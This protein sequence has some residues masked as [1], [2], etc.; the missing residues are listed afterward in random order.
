MLTLTHLNSQKAVY[1]EGFG[2]GV[3]YSL[4]YDQDLDNSP[5]GWGFRVGISFIPI[6]NSDFISIPATLNY[7]IG[8]G[9]HFFDLGAGLSYYR[10]DA[11]FIEDFGNSHLSFIANVG[12]RYQKPRGIFFKA[13]ITPIL[14]KEFFAPYF[15]G[16]AFGYSF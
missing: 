8:Q 15:P 7:L 4:N 1:A 9:P 3:L 5:G 2:H 14:S 10:G 12:Y 13:G 11:S 16:V 6:H